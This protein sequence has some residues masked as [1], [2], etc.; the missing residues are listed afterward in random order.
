MKKVLII[1][2]GSGAFAAAADLTLRGH[3]V[4]L[5]AEN[6]YK[7]RLSKLLNEKEITLSGVG[8]IGTAKLYNATTDIEEALKDIDIIL[9]VIPAYTQ[10]RVA[11]LIA[12]YLNSQDKIILAP[13][14][15]GGALL[16]AKQLRK[17]GKQDVIIAEFHTL[18]Y[19][20][21]KTSENSAKILL[22][23]KK[24]YFAAFPA[25]YNQEMYE[26]AKDLYPS[27]YLVK[28]VLETSLNNGNPVS[29]PA[30]VV[31]NAGKIE[32]SNGEHYHYREGITP[33]VARVN[34]KIDLERQSIC[35]ILG[36]EQI[37]I[38]TRLFEMGYAPKR[39][40]LYECYRDS[41]S[42]SPLKGPVNLDDR[43]LTEDTPYA[44]V[45]LSKLGKQLG[46][47]TP[48]MDA[49]ITLAATLKDQDYWAQGRDTKDIGIKDLDKDE[50][51]KFLFEGY[52]KDN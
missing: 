25:K 15:T 43:Y 2:G 35:K 24:L 18:P 17:Y 23:C 48:V 1:G 21:R 13:G 3:R 6:R 10:E 27:S 9:P 39:E 7:E 38:K 4:T 41:E 52:K 11:N 36:Y 30:P 47:D 26:I 44:L 29:H 31:L 20:A 19:A 45:L 14:S 33:S 8:I 5:F 46:I 42:F 32:Y 37:D 34:E 40:T 16:F 51:N 22:E 50:I 28:D 12:P 49:I